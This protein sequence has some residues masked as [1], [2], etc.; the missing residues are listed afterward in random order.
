M[1]DIDTSLDGLLADATVA[2]SVTKKISVKPN[3]H[4][5]IAL[6]ATLPAGTYFVAI[7]LDPNNAFNDTNRA[8]NFFASASKATVS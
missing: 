7:N 1:I 8:N 3:A 4:S 5:S 2:T 6:S